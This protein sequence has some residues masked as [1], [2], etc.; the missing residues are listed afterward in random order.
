MPKR[1]FKFVALGEATRYIRGTTPQKIREKRRRKK[2][3][4]AVLAYMYS[5]ARHV[6]LPLIP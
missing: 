2:K 4:F 6:G 1:L 5:E 3:P